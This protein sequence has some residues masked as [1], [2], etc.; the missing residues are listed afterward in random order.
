MVGLHAEELTL[1]RWL[2]IAR[3]GLSRLQAREAAAAVREG[4]V[5]LDIRSELQRERDGVVPGAVFIPRNV[6]EWRCSPSSDARDVRVSDPRLLLILM[7]HEGYQS[8]LAAAT[9]RLLGMPRATD[10][11]G[12]F[13]SWL[14]AGLPVEAI[15]RPRRERASAARRAHRPRAPAQAS[16]PEFGPPPQG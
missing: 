4:A 3:A 10:L 6:L 15:A 16:A 13:R 12:G 8:S 2:A 7:C 1:D 9:L 14:R 11:I 5:L